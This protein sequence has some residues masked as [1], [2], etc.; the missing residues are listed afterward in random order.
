MRDKGHKVLL[1]VTDYI[2][3]NIPSKRRGGYRCYSLKTNY[4]LWWPW[5]TRSVTGGEENRKKE[6]TMMA[7]KWNTCPKSNYL[8]KVWVWRSRR[9]RKCTAWH[10]ALIDVTPQRTRNGHVYLGSKVSNLQK[11][12]LFHL[13]IHALS[14]HNCRTQ[15]ALWDPYYKSI[16]SIVYVCNRLAI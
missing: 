11:L 14:N 7:K 9:L 15:G 16:P 5:R 3:K 13:S 8:C 10:N 6:K 1:R 2:Y 4:W 12:Q